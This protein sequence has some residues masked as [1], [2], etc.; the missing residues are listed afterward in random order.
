VPL[1]HDLVYDVGLHKGEDS[2]FYLAK[3]YRVVAF[4]ANPDLVRYCT[5]RFS[6][7]IEAGRLEIIEGAITDS[8]QATVRFYIHPVSV[9]GTTSEELVARNLVIAESRP[10]EVP[11]VRFADVLRHT[12]IPS[13]MKVD[14]E[15]AETIC[16]EALA[17]FDER[18]LSVSIESDQS[19]WGRLLHEFALLERLG[20]D[21]F[22][23]IQQ[24]GIAGRTVTTSTLDGSSLT[25]S[26]EQDASGAFGSDV[27]PWVDRAAALAK[28]KRI[29]LSYKLFGAGTIFRKFRLGRNL[30]DIAARYLGMPG[31]VDTHAAE[32]ARRLPPTFL[33]ESGD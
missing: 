27:G 7:E 20:Y 4:E 28:Y 21:R 12:G 17:Q 33:K 29:F 9:W 31:W 15:G 16:L 2:A 25:F 6:A 30:P 5:G 23:V 11:T 32:S 13:F 8:S 22:A 3:G 10:I 26:F 19:D 1:V 18:P 14:I 24:A